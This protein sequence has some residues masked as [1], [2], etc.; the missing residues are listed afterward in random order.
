MFYEYL[1]MFCEYLNMFHGYLSIFYEQV[2]MFYEYLERSTHVKSTDARA[3]SSKAP[4]VHTSGRSSWERSCD[5]MPKYLTPARMNKH[6][7]GH[8]L[9]SCPKRSIGMSS[10]PQA[11]SLTMRTMALAWVFALAPC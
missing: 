7:N 8:Q 5:H 9:S 11:L 4:L 10:T 2:Y 3:Q 6:A 1:Y